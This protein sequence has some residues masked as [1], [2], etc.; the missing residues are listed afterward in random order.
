MGEYRY[1]IEG[2]SC[3]GCVN[4]VTRILQQTL[5]AA[6]VQVS[7]EPG[8]ALLRCDAPPSEE[9]LRQALAKGGFRLTGELPS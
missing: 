7:L 3:G 8:A 2:M 5:P 9:A 6:E 1:G 4:S